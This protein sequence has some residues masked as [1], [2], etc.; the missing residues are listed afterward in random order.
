MKTQL[1]HNSFQVTPLHTIIR[2][3]HIQLKSTKTIVPSSLLFHKVHTLISCNYVVCNQTSW[4]KGRLF[5]RYNL[6]QD[7]FKSVGHQLRRNLVNH[8]TQAYRPKLA[9]LLW[10]I[11]LRDQNDA[12]VVNY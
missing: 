2:L 9:K 3:P 1:E 6:R 11:N 7:E 12:C 5:L 4:H 8:I 10:T